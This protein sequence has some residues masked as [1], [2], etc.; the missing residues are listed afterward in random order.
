MA[1]I[2]TAVHNGEAPLAIERLP[3]DELLGI[4]A[5]EEGEVSGGV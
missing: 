2:F 5:P 4:A 1:R 3:L